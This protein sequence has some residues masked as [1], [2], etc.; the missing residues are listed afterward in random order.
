[1]IGSLGLYRLGWE[2]GA[3]GCEGDV[4]CA[5]KPTVCMCL[6]GRAQEGEEE[7]EGGGKEERTIRTRGKQ[8]KNHFRERKTKSHTF[9]DT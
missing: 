1:M 9:F 6:E 8:N 4:L 5:L 3:K 7:Q 2:R